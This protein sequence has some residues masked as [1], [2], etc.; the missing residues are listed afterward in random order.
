VEF[1]SDEG[2]DIEQCPVHVAL[3]KCAVEEGRGDM[4]TFA[5]DT[6]EFT[7]NENLLLPG[8]PL[9]KGASQRLR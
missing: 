2:G 4:Q 8:D 7:E 9:P 1:C 5:L 3:P 6:L